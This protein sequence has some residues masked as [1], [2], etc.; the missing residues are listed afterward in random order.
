M[1]ARHTGDIAA[2]VRIANPDVGAV[3][4]VG[5]AHLG[6]FGSRAK[7]AETKAELIHGLRDGAIAVLG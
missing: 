5:T 6:E 3:L 4:R 1:G 7:I 2:L